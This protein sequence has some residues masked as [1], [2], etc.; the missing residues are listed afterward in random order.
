MSAF[1]IFIIL[2][3]LAGLYLV[4]NY[5]SLVRL[6]NQVKNAW[7]QI[8]VQLKRRHDLIP[9]LIETVKGYMSHERETLE[10][11]TNARSQAMKASTVAEKAKAESALSGALGR[12][13][14]VVENYPDF[15]S[16]QN[17]L[18]LQEEL[19][20]TENKI[21][22]ARQNYNDQVLRYNNKIEMFPSNIIAGMF[23]FT[24]EDFFEIETKEER[25]V[26]K[27][28]FGK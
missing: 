13:N 2:I 25:E 8:D 24:K 1:A 4:S 3:I 28:D 11:I 27:V 6:R 19:T 7:S 16:N 10:N 17:F 20:S 26:P 14:V 18:A 22:F 5:N 9:N 12:F 23:N 21:S 15:K